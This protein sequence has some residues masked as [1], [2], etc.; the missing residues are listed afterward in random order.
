MG[1]KDWLVGV[2][3][4][5]PQHW[6]DPRIRANDIDRTADLERRGWR[7]IRVSSELLRER[8]GVVVARARRALQ[9]AGCPLI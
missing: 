4:D 8:P 6:T 7:L 2:E 5:G 9:A 1:W 3:Y